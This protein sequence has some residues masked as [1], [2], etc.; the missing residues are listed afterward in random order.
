[1][2]RVDLWPHVLEDWWLSD[3]SCV[4]QCSYQHKR[5]DLS[6]NLDSRSVCWQ[7]Y[8]YKCVGVVCFRRSSEGA[9]ERG[10][11]PPTLTITVL[12]T[13]TVTSGS[14]RSLSERYVT[15]YA[16]CVEYIHIVRRFSTTSYT[17]SAI[18]IRMAL[19]PECYVFSMIVCITANRTYYRPD[20]V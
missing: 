1:M 13:V 15:S 2:R 16:F 4:L 3:Y 18:Y 20:L 19:L 11:D 10:S 8:V 17:V 6:R 14:S 12:S 5:Y 7:V 9:A